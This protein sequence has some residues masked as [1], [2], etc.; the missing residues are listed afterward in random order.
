MPAK[1]TMSSTARRSRFSL[2]LRWQAMAAGQRPRPQEQGTP[3]TRVRPKGKGHG[4][5]P[6]ATLLPRRDG[7]RNLQCPPYL[8]CPGAG[9]G[10]CLC[11]PV[12]PPRVLRCHLRGRWDG[13]WSQDSPARWHHG[14]AMA[15]AGGEAVGTGWWAPG[16][17]RAGAAARPRWPPAPGAPV[18]QAAA[19]TARYFSSRG[20]CGAIPGTFTSP[21]AAAPGQSPRTAPRGPN[22]PRF[23]GSP[24]PRPAPLPSPPVI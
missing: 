4:E 1:A 20:C 15:P 2:V 3:Q 24:A 6:P 11:P 18:E 21:W 17:A 9:A 12:H 22:Q 19:H 13:G 14:V 7:Q 16:T 10:T 8:M 23:G 5:T